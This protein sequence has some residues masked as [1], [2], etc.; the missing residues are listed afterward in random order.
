MST[1]Y[2]RIARIL[3]QAFTCETFSFAWGSC[4]LHG[5]SND[6]FNFMC[7]S[8]ACTNAIAP[9]FDFGKRNNEIDNLF[10][11]ADRG[12]TAT[13][14]QLDKALFICRAKWC[15]H[16]GIDNKI[17]VAEWRVHCISKSGSFHRRRKFRGSCILCYRVN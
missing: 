17:Q 3:F 11:F 2:T 6:D 1:K 14:E 13:N 10:R 16:I 12:G 7:T 8:G 4:E 9:V 5:T 15:T